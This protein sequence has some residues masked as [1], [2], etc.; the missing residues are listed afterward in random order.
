M[1]QEKKENNDKNET[2]YKV[3]WGPSTFAQLE[4][5]EVLWN[6]MSGTFVYG[7]QFSSDEEDSLVRFKKYTRLMDSIRSTEEC[8]SNIADHQEALR[9]VAM[10]S[11]SGTA[12]KFFINSW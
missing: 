9:L 1:L 10:Q 6:A 3:M 7:E 8:Y 11:L 2:N 12:Y 4:N 5:I